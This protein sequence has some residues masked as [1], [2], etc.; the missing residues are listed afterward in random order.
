MKKDITDTTRMETDA[1]LRKLRKT[2]DARKND[3]GALDLALMHGLCHV[4]SDLPHASASSM[5]RL[6]EELLARQARPDE[7]N[8]AM[9]QGESKDAQAGLHYADYK[10]E[11]DDDWRVGFPRQYGSK[12]PEGITDT[13]GWNDDQLRQR[14]ERV[15]VVLDWANTTGSARKWWEAFESENS[16]RLA[17]VLRLAEELKNRNATITEFFLAYVYSNTDNIQANLLYLDYTRLKKEEE[18]K[19]REAAAKAEA[20]GTSKP[21]S[22]APGSSTG[23]TSGSTRAVSKGSGGNDS[24]ELTFVRCESCRSLVPAVSTRCRM[25]GAPLEKE[26]DV[27]IQELGLPGRATKLLTAA[28]LT[29]VGTLTAKTE[30]EVLALPGIGTA[31]V[32]KLRVALKGRGF[33]FDSEPLASRGLVGFVGR[34]V[35]ARAVATRAALNAE[36]RK[37]AKGKLFDDRYVLEEVVGLGSRGLVYRAR[38]ARGDEATVALKV[39]DQE[40]GGEGPTSDELRKEALAMVS[41]RHQYAIRLDDFHSVGPVGYLSMEYAPHGSLRSFAQAHGGR[42]G[43]SFAKLYLL[44]VGDALHFA[45]QAGLLHR[46]IELD[47]VLVVDKTE[48]RLSGFGRATLPGEESSIP[49]GTLIPP[50]LRHGGAYN[51]RADLYQLGAAFF[52]VLTGE[53]AFDERGNRVGPSLTERLPNA[54]T[55]LTQAV[56]RLLAPDPGHA[57]A[58]AKELTQALLPNEGAAA[59]DQS[60]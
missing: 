9:Q 43:P 20:A 14:L 40:S 37:A 18:R 27:S 35:K 58:T 32:Q 41:C 48:A 13:R 21:A 49:D 28:G 15:K 17:L 11:T 23:G 12:A 56:E 3:L 10:R 19:K 51:R 53:S 42:I 57:F 26:Q 1:I 46:A 34:Q 47:H 39:L 22:G 5:L 4:P 50:E 8:E 7:F 52:E 45:H 55:Q 6:V 59:A 16:Y 33:A 30:A 25:C 36:L 54:S 60:G 29:T 31:T 38:Y 24:T 2:I 44:Q